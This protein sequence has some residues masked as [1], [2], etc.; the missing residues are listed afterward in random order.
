MLYELLVLLVSVISL[1]APCSDCVRQF[2]VRCIFRPLMLYDLCLLMLY[3][4]IVL[5]C[6]MLP[7][8]PFEW[9]DR[10]CEP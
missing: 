5:L 7:R 9:P 1:R 4:L 6:L 2:V 8:A 3:E 10:Q